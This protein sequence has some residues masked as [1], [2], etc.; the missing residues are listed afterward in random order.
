ML[1]GTQ[2]LDDFSLKQ[3]HVLSEERLGKKKRVCL[4]LI[5]YDLSK[6]CLSYWLDV[7][8]EFDTIHIKK[9]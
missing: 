2:P 3:I 4:T 5:F 8:D 6:V 7:M 1:K 9:K